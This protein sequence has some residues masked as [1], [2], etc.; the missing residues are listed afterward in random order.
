MALDFWA[1]RIHSLGNAT[2]LQIGIQLVQA[3]KKMGSTP[4]PRKR[5]VEGLAGTRLYKQPQPGKDL[6][7]L[8]GRSSPK[9][10]ERKGPTIGVGVVKGHHGYMQ[11]PV[12]EGAKEKGTP[13]SAAAALRGTFA[14]DPRGG[15]RQRVEHGWRGRLP[16]VETNRKGSQQQTAEAGLRGQK[17]PWQGGG[18]LDKT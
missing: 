18:P 11:T 12:D 14:E 10:P 1:A 4:A 7:L 13:H 6:A 3:C 5:E 2:G 8:R 16:L 17:Q 9:S 15:D